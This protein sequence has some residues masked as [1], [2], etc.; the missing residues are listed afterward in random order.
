[1]ES[2]VLKPCPFCGG[3]AKFISDMRTFSRSGYVECVICGARGKEFWA[4]MTYAARDK[5]VEAWNC[6]DGS[7]SLRDALE[8]VRDMC[9]SKDDCRDC[10]CYSPGT[11]ECVLT[12][13]NPA[14]WGSSRKEG[15]D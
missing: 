6:R 4:G 9:A 1:M 2:T 14:I 10:L 11:D 8:V 15:K 5:A 3:N 7:N 12:S 13:N